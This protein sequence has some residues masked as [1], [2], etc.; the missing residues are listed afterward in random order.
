MPMQAPA[1]D[2]AKGEP[3]E[4]RVKIAFSG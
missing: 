1:T 2:G 4:I 3:P